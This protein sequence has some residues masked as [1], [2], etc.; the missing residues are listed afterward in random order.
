MIKAFA[1]YFACYLQ[2]K[3]KKN[4]STVTAYM[5]LSYLLNQVSALGRKTVTACIE[6]TQY[7]QSS[8]DM[9]SLYLL[10]KISRQMVNVCNKKES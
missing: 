9:L 10:I 1:V 2:K 5:C 4:T 8:W 7:H 6:V 3:K